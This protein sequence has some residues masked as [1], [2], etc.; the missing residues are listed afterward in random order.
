VVDF[1]SLRI[2]ARE[3]A[4]RIENLK[5]KIEDA[6]LD[7]YVAGTVENAYYLSGLAYRPYERQFFVVVPRNDEPFLFV[8]KLE[9]EHAKKVSWINDV[10]SYSEYPGRP[11]EDWPAIMRKHLEGYRRVGLESSLPIGTAQ[12]F[13]TVGREVDI[14]DLV[15][16][17]RIVKSEKEVEKIRFAAKVADKIAQRLLKNSKEGAPLL[18]I[19]A[20]VSQE[21]YSTV[22]GKIPDANLLVTNST[23]AVWMGAISTMPHRAPSAFD[24]IKA[25]IP[26]VELTTVQA[27]GYSA[28]CERTFFAEQ[29]ED[30]AAKFYR[31]MIDAREAALHEVR[32]GVLC[33][34]VDLE[35]K[36]LLVKSG[37]E[38]NILHRTGHGI[39]IGTHEEPWV[40][41][42]W[43]RRLEENMVISI[44]PGIYFEG[45]GGF[46]HSD[47]VLV[48]RSGYE[49]LTKTPTDLKSL[50]IM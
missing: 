21:M 42:G 17:L 12:L 22:L 35:A 38:G 39:G 14:I 37:Y 23:A 33:S 18:T 29:V 2:D 7:A 1:L 40:A 30:K 49:L 6:R 45:Y 8:P 13:Q 15:E 4:R 27:D 46:R 43:D 25:G 3:Y 24:A 19:I 44:E 10:R 34:D 32:E 36:K 50:T 48:T 28:E 20:P 16:Q 5:S 11:N 41:E 26:N 31:D 47:T 9:E